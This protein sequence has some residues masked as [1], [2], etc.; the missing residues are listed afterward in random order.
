MQTINKQ[1][2]ET[3]SRDPEIKLRDQNQGKPQFDFLKADHPSNGMR[4]Q[5]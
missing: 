1:N 2:N 5:P 3:G 4:T